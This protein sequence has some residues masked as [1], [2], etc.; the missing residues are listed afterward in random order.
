MS[1]KLIF[2]TGACLISGS[3]H[4]MQQ[5]SQMWLKCLTTVFKVLQ[6]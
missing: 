5:K 6:I 1:V 2:T 4:K 3:K